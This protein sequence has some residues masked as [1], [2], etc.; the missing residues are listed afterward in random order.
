M[1]IAQLFQDERPEQPQIEPETGPN[2][3]SAKI[4]TIIKQ[5]K[6][7]W[8]D[9]HQDL[10]TSISLGKKLSILNKILQD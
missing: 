2:I 7:C 9:C 4:R 10:Y 8:Y 1:Y 6:D 5:M 3:L